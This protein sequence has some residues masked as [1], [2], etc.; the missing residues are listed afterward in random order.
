MARLRLVATA[1]R[2]ALAVVVGCAP[3]ADHV[4]VGADAAQVDGS[5]DGGL[6]S[7]SPDS[8][9][10]A[11]LDCADPRAFCDDFE[12]SVLLPREWDYV[13]GS[14]A[15]TIDLVPGQ[16]ALASQG[17]VV[18]FSAGD[19]EQKFLRKG[20]GGLGERSRARFAFAASITSEGYVQ[21]P[22]L[23]CGIETGPRLDIGV[24]F[25]AGTVKLSVH[26]PGCEACAPS[27]S[28][29]IL[30]EPGWHR[31]RVEL[32][33]EPGDPDLRRYGRARLHVDDVL[34]IDTD[35]GLPLSGHPQAD[36]L[37]GLNYAHQT[38]GILILD[39]AY[40]ALVDP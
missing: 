34:E 23:A 30:L 2:F 8:D 40:V 28:Q 39:D 24:L 1:E 11:P 25:D 32:D 16:G 12:G 29:Q 17:L 26:A 38:S 21:G 7:S 5:L 10:P 20:L 4:P 37:F 31:Y 19:N 27:P 35:L 3:F 15:P 13:G 14:Q 22:R 9:P 33:L 6:D 36:F 18:Q